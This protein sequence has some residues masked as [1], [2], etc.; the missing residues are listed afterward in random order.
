MRNLKKTRRKTKAITEALSLWEAEIQADLQ[1]L[2]VQFFRF[3]IPGPTSEP[4]RKLVHAGCHQHVLARAGAELLQPKL[5]NVQDGIRISRCILHLPV[6]GAQCTKATGVNRH[7]QLPGRP[8]GL[9]SHNFPHLPGGQAKI[10]YLSLE[11]C[12]AIDDL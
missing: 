7:V 10:L 5:E 6:L 1:T 8:G 3:S 11:I 9:D 4:P 12:H 2:P